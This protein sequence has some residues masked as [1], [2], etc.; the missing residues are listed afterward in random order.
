MLGN[1][2][3]YNTG[4]TRLSRMQEPRLEPYEGGLALQESGV[5]HLHG[6]GSLRG[7]DK[8]PSTDSNVTAV[9]GSK[10]ILLVNQSSG[11][12]M[13]VFTTGDTDFVF[14]GVGPVQVQSA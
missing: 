7:S 13:W 8:E 9:S 11:L 2:L 10:V 1:D 12:I 3:G 4:L 6:Q 5:I 14:T